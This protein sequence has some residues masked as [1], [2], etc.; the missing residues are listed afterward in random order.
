MESNLLFFASS[1]ASIYTT[2]RLIESLSGSRGDKLAFKFKTKSSMVGLIYAL[3]Y[4]MLHSR[5]TIVT[6][7]VNQ[8][9]NPI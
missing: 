1:I 6:L 7:N 5:H 9:M 2:F 8:K 3:I 4:T